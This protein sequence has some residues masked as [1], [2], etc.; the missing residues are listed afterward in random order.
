LISSDEL[1]TRNAQ[2]GPYIPTYES[3]CLGEN[4]VD[5]GWAPFESDSETFHQADLFMGAMAILPSLKHPFLNPLSIDHK[6]IRISTL[7]VAEDKK[8]ILIRVYNNSSTTVKSRF[9]VNSAHRNVLE[10]NLLEEPITAIS[11]TTLSFK[12]HELKHIKIVLK[13]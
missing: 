6:D 7:K 5:Y 2:V 8:G 4:V 9:V 12:P 10:S 11:D 1:T 3:Q 13:A